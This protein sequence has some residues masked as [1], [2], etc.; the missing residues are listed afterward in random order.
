MSQ[1]V[2]KIAVFIIILVIL[3]SIGSIYVSNKIETLRDKAYTELSHEIKNELEL[4]I[5]EK[6]EAVLLVALTLSHDR[7]IQKSLEKKRY[8][9]IHL[10]DLSA[11][12][13]TYTSLKNVW[14]QVID[15]NGISF[16]RS[17]TS[18]KGD[19]L[20]LIRM[21]VSKMLALHKIMSTI[22][23]GRYD[24]AFKSIVPITDKYGTFLGMVEVIAKFNSIVRKL[25]QKEYK[26]VI[27]VDKHYK[28]QLLSHSKSNVFIDDYYIVNPQ[29]N[30]EIVSLLKE[31]SVDTLLKEN[32]E[33]ILDTKHHYFITIMKKNGLDGEPMAY[34]FVFKPV[35]LLDMQSVE[36]EKQNLI[37]NLILLFLAFVV[38]IYVMYVTNY[39]K[40]IEKQNE[41]LNIA[42]EEKTQ[43]LQEQSQ[44]L[45]YL[46]HHDVLT[47]L[48][49]KNLL[50]D[51]MR[52]AIKHAKREG[53]SVAILFLD[54]D[55]FKEIN[56]M[57]GHDIG[58]ELLKQ[59]A[60]RLTS[61]IREEDTLA[62]I[63]GDEFVLILPSTSQ[64]NVVVVIEKIFDAMAEPFVVN[65]ID[66]YATFSIGVTLCPQDGET[67]EILLRNA[68]TAMYKAKDNGKNSYQFY[69]E[70]MTALI[71]KRIELDNDIRLGL[72]REEFEVYYQPKIDANNNKLVGL[73]ALVRWNHPL[74]GL[75]YPNDF[76]PFC[77]EVGLIVQLD[78]Y[79]L[80]HAFMQMQIWQNQGIDYG[81]LSINISTKKLE[82]EDFRHELYTLLEHYPVDP[83]TVELEILEGQIMKNPE[84][85]IGILNSIRSM[86]ISVAIDD[87]G[88]GYSSLSY[89]KK[90]PVTKLKI[91]RSFVVDVLENE[92]DA[93]IIR[94]IIVLGK[95]LGLDIIAEGVETKD[96]VDFLVDAGCNKIQGYYYSKPL[97]I[98]ECEAFI[99]KYSKG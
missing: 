17:W 21:D 89:L 88:T 47:N 67:P 77:E 53:T 99:Q 98:K 73:E 12:L 1:S 46:A 16:Y 76:I 24:L 44:K 55:R 78:S 25:N 41:K 2:R 50:I 42:V 70:E 22:S 68:D 59:I 9:N 96:H 35:A 60:K 82:S 19:D 93:A 11:L 48:P 38:F 62:R 18:K 72:Q 95:N 94:T 37:L 36:K 27:V 32:R 84:R 20:S 7:S 90:L 58:D 63:G 85:S 28:Q 56:D 10:D 69:D 13:Q 4:L 91:D 40:F 39:K 97:S 66:I 8:Q 86:G 30:E 64:V 31:Y 71:K 26:T 65:N 51:R 6:A 15:K 29:G 43:K 75:V 23:V 57:Y 83:T 81:E 79:V 5:S 14:F 54:L 87:F 74:K 92:D 52:Q 33:Y 49:N 61:Y 34:F 3:F 80:K 45:A